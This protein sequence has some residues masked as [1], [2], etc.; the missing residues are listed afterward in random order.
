[1]LRC[2]VCGRFAEKICQSKYFP[3]SFIVGFRNLR[4]LDFQ[5]HGW[6]DGMS[7]HVRPVEE[8]SGYYVGTTM[9]SYRMA[10]SALIFLCLGT[11]WALKFSASAQLWR[12]KQSN[13]TT[14]LYFNRIAL[15]MAYWKALY[16]LLVFFVLSKN[17]HHT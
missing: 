8:V 17:I 7:G 10:C 5:R 16:L 15:F 12:T 13:Y 6:Q 14:L 2:K 4:T 11:A 9:L 3:E 1:M